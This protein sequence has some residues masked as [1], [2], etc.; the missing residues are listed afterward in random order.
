MAGRLC[1]ELDPPGIEGL[2]LPALSTDDEYRDEFGFVFLDD[3]VA[4]PFYVSLPGTLP[5]LHRR[6]PRPAGARLPLDGCLRGFGSR[7]L[8][9]R[10]LA[11]GA[12][13]ALSQHLMRRAGFQFPPRGSGG[14]EPRSGERVGMD[15]PPASSRSTT[16][17]RV[18]K[19]PSWP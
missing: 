8:A 7:V 4:A 13:N 15:P 17:S 14:D 12:W 18:A 11:L 16:A 3:G 2:Y 1:A 9:D 5:E 19:R 10:A 6:F